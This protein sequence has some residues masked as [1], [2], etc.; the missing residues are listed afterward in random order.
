MSSLLHVARS[1]IDEQRKTRRVRPSLFD[2]FI[3]EDQARKNPAEAVSSGIRIRRQS[4]QRKEASATSENQ[5]HQSS[6]RL[7]RSGTLKERDWR[8]GPVRFTE[9]PPGL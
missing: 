7:H 8:I 1:L 6:Q 2:L 5:R 9:N 3:E 4:R